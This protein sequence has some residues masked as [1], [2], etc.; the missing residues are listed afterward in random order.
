[1]AGI[2]LLFLMSNSWL[3][4]LFLYV[5]IQVSLFKSFEENNI[6]Q[7]KNNFL[8]YGWHKSCFIRTLCQKS[9]RGSQLWPA[10]TCKVCWECSHFGQTLLHTELR[11]ACTTCSFLGP[12]RAGRTL[13]R[14]ELWA[15]PHVRGQCLKRG[16]VSTKPSYASWDPGSKKENPSITA[17]GIWK[18]QGW[19][20]CGRAGKS[21]AVLLG[22]SDQKNKQPRLWVKML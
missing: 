2:S 4:P 16:T 22:G 19:F 17:V 6:I 15:G 13:R 18:N 7:F 8:N 5:S 9:I 11:E 20:F 1:M 21:C 14:T 10:V 3:L 12:Q